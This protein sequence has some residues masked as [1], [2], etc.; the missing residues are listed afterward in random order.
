MT[1][2]KSMGNFGDEMP[3]FTRRFNEYGVGE[4][5]LSPI[6][7]N[8]YSTGNPETNLATYLIK[9]KEFD[10][11]QVEIIDENNEDG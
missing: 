2:Q 11:S 1:V 10:K 9:Y 6:T 3:K 4:E 7:I 5:L 8:D